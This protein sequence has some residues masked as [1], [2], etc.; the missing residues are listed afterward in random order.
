MDDVGIGYWQAGNVFSVI[1]NKD[2]LSGDKINQA[3]VV[4][5]LNTAY[6][7]FPNYD[8]WGFNDDALYA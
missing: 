5:G 6:N 4:D 8:K 2:Y 3:T 1:A 7:Q